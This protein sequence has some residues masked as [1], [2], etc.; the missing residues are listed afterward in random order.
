VRNLT[1][2]TTWTVVGSA[3]SAVVTGATIAQGWTV[4]PVGNNET[5]A[6]T[7]QAFRIR[8][9]PD[10]CNSAG[11][12]MR[13]IRFRGIILDTYDVRECPI[14]LAG[15]SH[16]LASADGGFLWV[17][18][19]MIHSLDRT[20]VI[21]ELTP[22]RGTA[23]GDT[24]VTVIGTGLQPLDS[25]GNAMSSSD[26]INNTRVDFNGY[27]CVVASANDTAVTCV[28][29]ER[30]DGITPF[31]TEVFIA[32]RGRAFISGTSE[33]TTFKYVDK[34][35]DV[36]SWLDSEPPVDG[37]TVIIP[38]GQAIMLDVDSPK[39]FLLLVSGFLEFERKD[40]ALNATYIWIAGG[41]FQVGTEEA[42]FL[43][44]ATITLHGDRWWTIELPVIGSKM[45]AVTNLGGLQGGCH[46]ST[47]R[48]SSYGRD[49]TSTCPV[50]KVGKLDIHG[51]PGTS[52]TRLV[53]TASAG[54]TL[55]KLEE[56]VDWEVGARVLITQSQNGET[57]EVRLVK[58]IQDNGFTLEL[59]LPLEREHLGIWYFNDEIPT[60]T[61]VRAAV[62]L[63]TRNVKVQGDDA[64]E[65]PGNAYMFGVHMGC[66]HGGEL[67]VENTEVT[68]SGQAA[69]LG[70]YSSH[71]H[72]MS[73]GR[74][75][76]VADKAYLRN[77]SY[78]DTFQRAVVCHS[79]DYCMV[80]HNIAHRSKGHS[81]FTEEGQEHFALFEHNLAVSPQQH[82]LLL[83]DDMDPAGFWLPGFTGWHR[84]NLAVGCHRGWRLRV[85]SDGKKQT[86]LTFFNNSAHACGFGWHLKPPHAP[87]TL[88]TFKD[89]TVFRCSTGMFYYGTGNIFHDNHRFLECGTGHFMN[90]L[91]NNL[92][93]APFYHNLYLALDVLMQRMKSCMLAHR[94]HSWETAKYLELLPLEIGTAVS[95]DEEE[96]V[97]R[98][99]TGDLKVKELAARLQ[100]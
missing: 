9:L 53:E 25:Y 24:S 39:L 3:S 55:L 86:D 100:G 38:E 77:N 12:L 4:Y 94:T 51:K 7:A 41:E 43:H 74:T 13:G 50:R 83:D 45:L 8:I 73:P 1:G 52:W 75:I 56:S 91:S 92:H 22:N 10:A 82:P 20:P 14:E 96:L 68:R 84:H 11:E 97:Q 34:W 63:L 2:N 95:Q 27:S 31:S 71:W 47:M 32:G 99:A 98:V 59:D 66:F 16:P 93:T 90:H 42:P 87:P 89:F 62:G 44:R 78:H 57:E 48:L 37:D 5:G 70:R 6:I 79:T 64:S 60:P 49:F 65:R 80:Q 54:A 88:N 15:V 40:L 28:T 58:G 26:S 19:L 36:H 33:A 72:H 30:T 67:R 21:Y 76:D 18:M 17:P 46:T 23:R 81:F 35:S 69:N 61:D 85:I 29:V